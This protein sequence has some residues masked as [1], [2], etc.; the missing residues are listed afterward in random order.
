MRFPQRRIR[1][2]YRVYGEGEV[3]DS[4]EWSQPEAPTRGGGADEPS[5]RRLH[6]VVVMT[7][8]GA[9]VGVVAAFAL[10]SVGG[11]GGGRGGGTGRAGPGGVALSAKPAPRGALAR[12][13]AAA[14][15]Q[16][17]IAAIGSGGGSARGAGGPRLAARGGRGHG[18]RR[19]VPAP[20]GGG[21]APQV[22]VH[23]ST[24]SAQGAQ[25][26]PAGW[27][28]VAER[29]TSAVSESSSLAAARVAEGP[30]PAEHTSEFG[31][32]G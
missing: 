16:P 17:T 18:G 32:E 13:Q 4:E 9:G 15:A 28:T 26:D 27:Q 5:T 23:P 21:A 20:A 10:H 3:P 25:G 30:A 12:V 7:L 2:V 22:A 1:E 24:Q 11:F 8:L 6:R 29:P 19:H 31:F 14:P